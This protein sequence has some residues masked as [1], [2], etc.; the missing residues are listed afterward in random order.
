MTQGRSDKVSY[1]AVIVI[2]ILSLLLLLILP[3]VIILLLGVVLMFWPAL[4]FLLFLG[5]INY[6]AINRGISPVSPVIESRPELVGTIFGMGSELSLDQF[7]RPAGKPKSG[8]IWIAEV[9][10]ETIYIE[11]QTEAEAAMVLAKSGKDIKK[12]KS[13]R[14][15]VGG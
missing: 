2:T 12:I 3:G 15:H 6:L 13:L 11:A 7:S 10:K 14:L 9:G 1:G 8:P 5:L 4:L